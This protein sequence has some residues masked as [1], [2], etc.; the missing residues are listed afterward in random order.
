MLR[1]LT[2]NF[3]KSTFFVMPNSPPDKNYWASSVTKKATILVFSRDADT[4]FLLKTV[5]DES[6]YQVI[7][8]ENVDHC[9]EMVRM[10]KPHLVLM[11]VDYPFFDDITCL[12][13]LRASKEFGD[14]PIIL[15]SNYPSS[16]FQS[17]INSLNVQRHLTKPLDFNFLEDTLKK[18]IKNEIGPNP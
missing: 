13:E 3:Q 1:S 18:I 5:L 6:N 9:A 7:E 12:T 10:H 11:D 4:R 16:R 17:T 8:S 15:I 14:I 2:Q